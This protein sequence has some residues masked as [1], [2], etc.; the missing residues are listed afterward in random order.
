MLDQYASVNMYAI[1]VHR[2]TLPRAAIILRS[3]WAYTI[4]ADG[5]KKSR[6][7]T[8]GSYILRTKCLRDA[9]G[10][11]FAASMT[12]AEFRIFICIATY[13]NYIIW[14]ADATNA[15]AYSPPPKGEVYMA[16][17]QQYVE[18][19]HHTYPDHARI[20]LDYVMR[21]QHAL[22]GHPESGHLWQDT[23]TRYY[24]RRISR[25]LSMHLVS[26]LASGMANLFSYVA[27]LMILLAASASKET[28]FSFYASL[29]K[30]VPMVVEPG[31][32][33]LMYGVTILQTRHYNQI[34][35]EQYIG[36]LQREYEWLN[37]I[38]QIPIEKSRP[39]AES[40]AK[41]LDTV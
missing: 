30:E 21:V 2:R 35:M 29:D 23:S 22:Q 11:T 26:I 24:V 39:L 1:P 9:L 27:K 32:M 19:Y 16:V 17:D 28:L 37:D 10:P 18:W 31:P 3:L 20:N 41:Q 36:Q 40:T 7:V 33:P 4:K 13:L 15:F 14:G 25:T 5:R 12:Q 8:D 34:T 38:K 6:N